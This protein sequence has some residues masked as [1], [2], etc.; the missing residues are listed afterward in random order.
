MQTLQH[1]EVLKGRMSLEKTAL[2][3]KSALG[4]GATT[5]QSLTI[6]ATMQKA[7]TTTRPL[8]LPKLDLSKT[9]KATIGTTQGTT[10]TIGTTGTTGTIGST[11]ATLKKGTTIKKFEQPPAITVQPETTLR[12]YPAQKKATTPPKQIE[13]KKFQGGQMELKKKGGSKKGSAGDD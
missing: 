12:G 8:T 6:P 2:T 11:G 13:A 3:Q 1:A 4:T 9:T 7:M 10:G 5:V